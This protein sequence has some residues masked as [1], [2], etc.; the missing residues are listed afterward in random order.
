MSP[1]SKLAPARTAPQAA[2]P[3]PAAGPARPAAPRPSMNDFVLR[4]VC[5]V[6][7]VLPAAHGYKN[8]K[9]G[10]LRAWRA[11][12]TAA[13]AAHGPAALW[14]TSGETD[15]SSLF[16]EDRGRGRGFNEDLNR[17]GVRFFE[18]KLIDK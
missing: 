8:K 16:R 6:L 9:G 15:L 14:N 7:F 17:F 18:R 1:S 11:N 13:L 5:V 12:R 2:R 3:P 10:A 4:V